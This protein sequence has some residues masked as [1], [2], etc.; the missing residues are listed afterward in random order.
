MVPH[1]ARGCKLVQLF[2]K[3]ISALWFK[4][5]KRTLPGSLT[6]AVQWLRLHLP[7]VQVSSLVEE[8]RSNAL[9]PK[10]P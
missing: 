7:M 8:L 10:K 5:L 9:Q 6:L 3:T 1:R 4:S 2:C